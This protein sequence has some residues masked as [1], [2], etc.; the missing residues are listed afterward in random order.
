MV[1]LIAAPVEVRVQAGSSL[2]RVSGLGSREIGNLQ[3]NSN[4]TIRSSYQ[5]STSPGNSSFPSPRGG[6]ETGHNGDGNAKIT[7]L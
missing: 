4:L 2:S 7:P 1:N 6:Y 5:A 3:N